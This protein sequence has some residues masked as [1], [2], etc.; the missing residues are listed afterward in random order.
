MLVAETL[1][2]PVS[3]NLVSPSASWACSSPSPRT[4]LEAAASPLRLV[5]AEPLLRAWLLSAALAGLAAGLSGVLASL[6]LRIAM[7]GWRPGDLQAYM[8]VNSFLR[9]GSVGLLSP[10]VSSR[11]ETPRIVLVQV[12]ASVGA[13]LMQVLA[14]LSPQLLLWPGYLRDLL[15]FATPASAA[16]L[17]SQFGADKQAT[18]NSVNHLVSNLCTSLSFWLFSSPAL[19]QPQARDAAAAPFVV[20]FVLTAC[21]GAIKVHLVVPHLRRPCCRRKQAA[22]HLH[23]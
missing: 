21:S 15:A 8:S 13:S 11:W 9:T 4:A 7:Y 10:L 19:F 6:S 20:A 2:V 3:A 23:V 22:T 14:P 12:A 5:A 16:F 1:S 17:S 18:V